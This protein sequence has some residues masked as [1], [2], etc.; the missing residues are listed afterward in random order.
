MH[1][2]YLVRLPK[3]RLL[4]QSNSRLFGTRADENLCIAALLDPVSAHAGQSA[5][6]INAL[7]DIRVRTGGVINWWW[8]IFFDALTVACGRQGDLPIGDTHVRAGAR[9]VAFLRCWIRRG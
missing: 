8:R 3:T 2:T 4:A 7:A 1:V 5:R 9:N 6:L